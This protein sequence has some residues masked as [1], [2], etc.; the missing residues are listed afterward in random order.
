VGGLEILRWAHGGEGVGIAGAGPL[1]G[2]VVFASEVVPG[3]VVD[4]EIM[5]GGDR[6]ARGRVVRQVRAS[7]E[8]VAV[9]CAV[10]ARCGGCPW[11]AGSAAVQAASRKA[12]LLGEL[13][14]RLGLEAHVEP[15][16]D[17]ELVVELRE[18]PQ[19]F[20][21]R[22]RLRLTFAVD[23]EHVRLGFLGKRSHQLVDIQRCEVA[24]PRLNEV[25]LALRARLMT[26]GGE[27]RVTLLAGSDGVAGVRIAAIPSA[28]TVSKSRLMS[29]RTCCALT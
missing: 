3:D 9:P 2:R 23:G 25:L 7:P 12:I 5:D 22:Q 15:A 24:D 27:G 16:G 20:G 11:M 26:L 4:V 6:W 17:E 28:N 1:A 18:S 21:Y 8:R 13:K 29:V 19:R 10:Q 14:K